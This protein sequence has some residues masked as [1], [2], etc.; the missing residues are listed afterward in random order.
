LCDEQVFKAVGEDCGF[1]QLQDAEDSVSIIAGI[2]RGLSS[3][4]AVGNAP[5]TRGRGVREPAELQAW[6]ARVRL[7][8]SPSIWH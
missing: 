8:A 1:R 6:A 2:Q 7:P 3:T 5:R 4:P